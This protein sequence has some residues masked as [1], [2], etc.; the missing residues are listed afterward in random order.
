M[1]LLQVTPAALK[2]LN[3]YQK[4]LQM[5][6]IPPEIIKTRISFDTDA[7]FPKLMFG[8]GGFLDEEG[9]SAVD[10]LFGSAQVKEITGE[11]APVAAPATAPAP[12]PQL[13]KPKP[14][15]APVQE[16]AAPE[17]EA[18]AT[19]KRGFGA[20]AAAPAA[21]TAAAPAPAPKPKPAA[22]VAAP[23]SNIADEIAALIGE[24]NADDA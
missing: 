20:K 8:F 18:P 15:P 3:Q 12:K 13:V 4:E 6:G 9:M 14:A 21:E 2:G 11:E 19:P 10:G 23:A 24:T 7:S 22:K 17:E 5:R 1:Y 16:E